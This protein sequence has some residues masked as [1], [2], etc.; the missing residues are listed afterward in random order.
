M[1][2]RPRMSQLEAPALQTPSP[3]RPR[4]RA[5]WALR[6]SLAFLL[7]A[8]GLAIAGIRYY[9]WC[10]GAGGPQRKVSVRIPEGASGAEIVNE[11]HDAGVVRCATVSQWLLRRSGLSEKIRAGR[12]RLA[13][14]M[15]PDE[16]FAAITK[17]PKAVPTVDVTIPEGYRLTQMAARFQLDLGIA[18]KRF[19]ATAG[20]GTW[21]L[22]PY[23]PKGKPLEGFLFPNTYEFAS[24]GTSADDVIRRLLDEFGTE[25]AGLPWSNATDLGVSPYDVV[26]VA[27]MI[28]KEA[29]IERDRPL[30][31]AV[32]YNRLHRGMTLGI[33]AT[34]QYV[35]PDPS[36][37]LTASDFKIDSPYNTRT[38]AG[39]PPTPIGSPGLASLRAA[40]TPAHADYLYYVLCGS[41]G[42]HVFSVSYDQFLR[43][44]SRCLG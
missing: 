16:A 8:S 7:V 12:Y 22:P 2:A 15:T 18:P 44:K 24:R 20:D 26:I 5:N 9:K 29:G 19:L 37:G 21:S 40:L 25:V 11:L 42:H 14:N 36:D 23:L 35:D 43:D 34:L 3:R 4:R 41:D 38:H 27:S 32:I 10:E 33:D 31:A 6:L 39:L 17:P 30:I 13:T 28:E 1:Y